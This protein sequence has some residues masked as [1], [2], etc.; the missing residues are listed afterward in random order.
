MSQLRV[1]PAA[2]H[3]SGKQVSEL[4]ETLRSE[5]ASAS[6]QIVAAQSG[7]IGKSAAALAAKL[8][9][10]DENAEIY[11]SNISG[12]GERFVAAA[13]MYGHTDES[14]A[15]TLKSAGDAIDSRTI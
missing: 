3:E 9:E 15:D 1:D 10:W 13:A 12:H 6:Q 7:W 14:E 8:A 2:V 11:H 4:A 5:F